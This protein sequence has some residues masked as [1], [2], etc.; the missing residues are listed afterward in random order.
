MADIKAK[1]IDKLETWTP[2]ELRKLRMVAKNRIASLSSSKEPKDLPKNH[3]LHDMESGEIN[4]LLLK[5]AKVE[6]G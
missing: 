4:E 5:V 3:P 6:K 1:D 2:K